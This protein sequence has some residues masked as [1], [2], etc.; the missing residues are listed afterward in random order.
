MS[1]ENVVFSESLIAGADLSS[2]Q[3]H[4]VKL[5]AARTIVAATAGECYGI[6]QNKPK[7]GEAANV[8]RMGFSFAACGGVLAVGDYMTTNADA[9]FVVLTPADGSTFS[10]CVAIAREVAA[11]GDL[12]SATAVGPFPVSTA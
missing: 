4:G 9:E 2:L 12:I 7:N 3:F 8:A 1:T 6:L 10:D 11:D 5:S